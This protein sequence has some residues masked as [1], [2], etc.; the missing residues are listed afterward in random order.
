MSE[1]SNDWWAGYAQGR[2]DEQ[3]AAVQRVEALL[4]EWQTF[5]E[6]IAKVTAAIKGESEPG[7]CPQCRDRIDFHY[8]DGEGRWFC[9]YCPCDYAIKGES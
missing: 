1:R 9:R 7:Y 5:P 6:N 3:N 8:Q 4:D 2:A